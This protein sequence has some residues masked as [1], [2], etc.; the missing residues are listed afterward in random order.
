MH[1]GVCVNKANITLTLPLTLTWILTLTLPLTLTLTLTL[2]G[3]VDEGKTEMQGKL[4]HPA[5]VRVRFV[6]VRV[7]VGKMEGTVR[8][9][10]EVVV[11]N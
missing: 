2:I 11:S 4:R 6:R 10:T 1:A 9:L 8:H 5:E 7:R 3:L